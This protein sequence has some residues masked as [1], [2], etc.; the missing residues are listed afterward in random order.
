[1]SAE[2]EKEPNSLSNLEPRARFS[3]LKPDSPKLVVDETVNLGWQPNDESY[4]RVF[5]GT[6][7]LTCSGVEIT[8]WGD[9][10]PDGTIDRT[11]TVFGPDEI[12]PGY[13]DDPWADNGARLHHT[14][15]DSL[16]ITA[17]E[18]RCIASALMEAADE[19]DGLR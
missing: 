17:D 14:N 2:F 6:E 16:N 4:S 12:E 13:E 1:V 3:G 11:I 19:I 10:L 18:A 9:E 5:A 8:V 7:R 15:V